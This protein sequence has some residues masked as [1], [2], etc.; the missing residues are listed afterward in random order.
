MLGAAVLAFFFCLNLKD[1][2]APPVGR[3]L[4]RLPVASTGNDNGFF[5]LWG[6]CESPATDPL[7]GEFRRRVLSLLAPFPSELE[8]RRRYGDWLDRTNDNF[9]RYWKGA[10]IPF[11]RGDSGDSGEFFLSRRALIEKKEK[12]FALLLHRFQALLSAGRIEDFTPPGRELPL[13]NLLLAINASRIFI[14]ANTVKALIGEPDK[15]SAATDNLLLSLAAGLK[16]IRSS[17]TLAVNF[18]GKTLADQSLRALAALLNRPALAAAIAVRVC[19][20]LPPRRTEEFGT[21]SVRH[22][23]TLSFIQALERIRREKVIDVRLLP[24]YFRW[25]ANVYAIERL[26]NKADP[27]TAQ[28]LQALLSFFLL[29]NETVGVFA[30]YW[31]SVGRLEE[32]PPWRWRSE[33]RALELDMTAGS[34]WWLRNP[35]GKM[36]VHSAVPHVRTVTLNFV[37]RTYESQVRYE[38][39]R[40]LSAFRCA[41][42]GAP[43][44]EK[45]RNLKR[46]LQAA[47]ERDPFSGGPY[48]YSVSR[49]VLYSVGP[50]RRDDGGMEREAFWRASD[51]AIPALVF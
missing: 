14:A 48:R 17:R 20:F 6:I 44:R 13:R 49:R 23:G 8:F 1:S 7:S 12:E 26:I 45:E 33:P 42:P 15:R 34:F 30:K 29:K 10:A 38:L 35:L 50:D 41:A 21:S 37:Y 16:L 22:S 2:S 51:I 19:G 28:A 36:M 3:S 18:L 25:S 24:G 5:I 39:V 11:P 9:R 43:E 46:F 31:E 32:T 27:R 40:I 47:A 4:G